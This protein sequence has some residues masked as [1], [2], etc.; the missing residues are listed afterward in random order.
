MLI[1]L[2]RLDHARTPTW[3]FR[4]ASSLTAPPRHEIAQE[5]YAPPSALVGGSPGG[6]SEQSRGA[7]SGSS[8]RTVS[9]APARLRAPGVA[10]PPERGFGSSTLTENRPREFS[11]SCARRVLRPTNAAEPQPGGV[12]GPLRPLGAH[13]LQEPAP[14]T[15]LRE[16]AMLPPRGIPPAGAA[17]FALGKT[18]GQ[19]GATADVPP[20]TIPS[21]KPRDSRGAPLNPDTCGPGT[22][23]LSPSTRGPVRL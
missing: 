1:H 9:A 15:A 2:P 11:G 10:I 4:L 8:D 22:C 17:A 19:T 14:R 3:R 13:P 16:G 18:P 5:A 12:T 6:D 21:L 23:S 7:P 20:T